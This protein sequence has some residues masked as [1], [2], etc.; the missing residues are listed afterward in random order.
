MFA[1]MGVIPEW[2]DENVSIGVMLGPCTHPAYT[3]FGPIY[4]KENME[5][6]A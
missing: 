1:G 3:Y 5:C 2:Y 6:L 4:T